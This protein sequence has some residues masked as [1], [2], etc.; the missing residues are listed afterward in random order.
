METLIKTATASSPYLE[1]NAATGQ[2]RITGRA[3]DSNPNEFWSSV[4]SWTTD[5]FKNS[6]DKIGTKFLNIGLLNG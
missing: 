3:I 5:Y 1:M 6:F 2:I 4:F